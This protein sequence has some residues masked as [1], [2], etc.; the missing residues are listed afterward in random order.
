MKI[1]GITSPWIFRTC[2]LL[3]ALLG[4]FF[5]YKLS[6]MI[7]EDWIKS[8]LVTMIA[9]TSPTY[10]YY[11]NGFI[12]GIPA[13]TFAIIALYCYVKYL[14]NSEIRTFCLSITFITLSVLTRMSFAVI[15]VALLGFEFLRIFTQ[16]TKTLLQLKIQSSPLL[17]AQQTALLPWLRLSTITLLSRA[18]SWQQSTLTQVTR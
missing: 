18:V 6:F 13:L 11:F 4:M 3:V 8:L 1:T 2:T 14:N 9:M 17:P 5:L 15:W 12:P 16:L 10:A 7:T